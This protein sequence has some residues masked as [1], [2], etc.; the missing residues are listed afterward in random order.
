[1]LSVVFPGEPSGPEIEE[2]L[3]NFKGLSEIEVVIVGLKEGA[4]RAQRSN[5]GFHRS[6]GKII[7]F[8]IHALIRIL[9]VLIFSFSSAETVTENL[10][11]VALLT[12]LI[13]ITPF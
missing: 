6:Q 4:S 11:G 3:R 8:I 12:N 1:M 7:L 5:L 9:L 2:S 10:L 13:F